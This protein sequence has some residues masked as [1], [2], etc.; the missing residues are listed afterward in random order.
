MTGQGESARAAARPP[1]EAVF[2]DHRTVIL[3][4]AGHF[5]GED[6]P[7]EIIAAIREWSERGV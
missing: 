4:A 5:I 1:W 2:A 3:E 7:Q 6:A